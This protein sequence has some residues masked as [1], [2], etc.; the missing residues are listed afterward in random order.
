M[1]LTCV[2]RQHHLVSANR[3]PGL[4]FKSCVSGTRIQPN[5]NYSNLPAQL[6][7]RKRQS[8]QAF[9]VPAALVRIAQT[10][11]IRGA[12]GRLLLAT[13]KRGLGWRLAPL[14]TAVLFI[15]SVVATWFAARQTKELAR[16]TDGGE[17]SPS[18]ATAST[19]QSYLAS[20]SGA[21]IDVENGN[22]SSTE[23]Q[24][25]LTDACPLCHGRG[26]ITWDRF[27][28]NESALCPRCLGSGATK[29]RSSFF[30]K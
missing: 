29:K 14:V 27:E 19:T 13:V 5:R 20:T 26:T 18:Q 28:T 3:F 6:P 12:S 4:G 24:Q 1:R 8:I 2:A 25:M 23:S 15:Y 11:V 30:G 22:V 10:V 7:L 9:V 21:S 17:I 16:V